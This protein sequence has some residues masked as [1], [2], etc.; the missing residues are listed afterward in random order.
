ML[1]IEH[2]RNTFSILKS[3]TADEDQQIASL[4]YKMNFYCIEFKSAVSVTT[5]QLLSSGISGLDVALNS[6]S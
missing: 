1:E 5:D 4:Y 2:R 3:K 6:H